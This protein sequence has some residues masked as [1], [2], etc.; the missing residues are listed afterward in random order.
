MSESVPDQKKKSFKNLLKAQLQQ[1]LFWD[2]GYSE[3]M[4]DFSLPSY[5]LHIQ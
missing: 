1:Q 4:Q 5:T 2:K 3:N